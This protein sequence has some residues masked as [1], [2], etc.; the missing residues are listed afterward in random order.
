MQ[1]FPLNLAASYWPT[2]D[3]V[4]Q[5]KTGRCP[6]VFDAY[7]DEQG[8]LYRRPGLAELV[9]T[10]N[11]RSITGVHWW[12]RRKMAL[13]VDD[14]GNVY[15]IEDKAGG[16]VITDITGDSLTGSRKP[17]IT[18][19]DDT[20]ILADGGRMVFTDGFTDTAFVGDTNAPTE[21][22]HVAFYDQYIVANLLGTGTFYHSEV[23]DRTDWRAINFFTAEA[24]P[25]KLQAIII[26]SQR[27]WLVGELS[28]EVWRND[29]VSPFVRINSSYIGSGT[30]APYSV[31]PISNSGMYIDQDFNVDTI[32]SG[33]PRARSKA[34]ESFIKG[35]ASVSDAVACSI[36]I[37]GRNFYVV[38]FP[39]ANVTLAYD[40]VLDNWYRWGYWNIYSDTYDR[41]LGSCT[42][43]ADSW[44]MTLVGSHKNDGK[45][46]EM[47]TSYT[48]DDG[49]KVR[50]LYRTGPDNYGSSNEKLGNHV[51][52]RVKRGIGSAG[53][54]AP[55]LM[56]R[57]KDNNRMW[58]T[59]LT[60][61]L[62]DVGDYNTEIYIAAPGR[63]RTREWEFSMTDEGRV[64]IVDGTEYIEVLSR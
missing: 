53:G 41:W 28:I 20:A 17:T 14:G 42:A 25:D 59:L 15:K 29:G 1:P 54:T 44:G 5:F 62:A 8:V 34:V 18:N 47:S 24:L 10:G 56:V 9:N 16:K 55:V 61:D 58:S 19:D 35:L 13:V 36:N 48:D 6:E 64:A 26:H 60:Y 46:Y 57:Y 51:I 38:S 39:T 4:A 32:L 31:I 40:W 23:G 11:G 7:S 45:V 37:D 50:M 49:D 12:N 30:P 43:F 22:S 21:V 27:M 63:F 2:S 33:A 3:K 52:L